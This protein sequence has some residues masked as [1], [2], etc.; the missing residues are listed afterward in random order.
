MSSKIRNHE[1]NDAAVKEYLVTF[2]SEELSELCPMLSLGPAWYSRIV[3]EMQL[4]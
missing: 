1:F 2:L 4:V 3:P